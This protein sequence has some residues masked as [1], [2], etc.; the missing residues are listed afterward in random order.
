MLY[1]LLRSIFSWVATLSSKGARPKLS[2]T[3]AVLKYALISITWCAP[4]WW[5]AENF[6]VDRTAYGILNAYWGATKLSFV[7]LPAFLGTAGSES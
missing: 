3:Q 5:T 1:V 7:A 4:I 6:D 2:D